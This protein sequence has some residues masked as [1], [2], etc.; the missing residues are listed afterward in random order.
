MNLL[1]SFRDFTFDFT[2][3]IDFTLH[4]F[5]TEIS[6]DF[7]LELRFDGKHKLEILYLKLHVLMNSAHIGCILTGR[8]DGAHVKIG[9]LGSDHHDVFF[10][11]SPL[12]EEHNLTSMAG[13]VPLSKFL[14]DLAL[15]FKDLF[16]HKRDESR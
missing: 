5:R 14:P 7:L 16:D 3:Y 1:G 6:L 4:K 2:F 11:K 15:N 9:E 8:E 12:Y 10:V 13:P